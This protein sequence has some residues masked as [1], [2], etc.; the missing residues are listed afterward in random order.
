MIASGVHHVGLTVADLD[1]AAT[2]W[3]ALLGVE[4]GPIEHLRGPQLGRLV[5]YPSATIDRRW[6]SMPGGV[7]L[8]LLR[9]L[10]GDEGPY[11]PGTA[12]PG[13]VHVCLAVEDMASAHAHA[14]ACGALEVTGGW[15]EVPAGP[16]AGARISYLRDPDGVTIELLQTPSGS[17]EP[18]S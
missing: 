11:E 10:D 16:M 4:A 6:V 18:R 13:N 1:R 5:G 15:I 3:A 14:L 7:A 8:E 9:Y 17:P 2:F 12:H